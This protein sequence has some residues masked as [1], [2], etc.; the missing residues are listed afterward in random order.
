ME[1]IAELVGVVLVLGPA[2]ASD[3][4]TGSGD[5]RDPGDSEELPWHPHRSVAYA[6]WTM[7]PSR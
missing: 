6:S 5:A 7:A 2:L 3:D 4:H 1:P